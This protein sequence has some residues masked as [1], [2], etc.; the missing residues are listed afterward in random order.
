MNIGELIGRAGEKVVDVLKF[1]LASND[2]FMAT[3]VSTYLFEKGFMSPCGKEF[4]KLKIQI[5]R[6]QVSFLSRVA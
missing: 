2:K 5:K 4:T 3:G 6:G 1:K